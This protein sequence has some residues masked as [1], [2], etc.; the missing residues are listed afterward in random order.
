M[1]PIYVTKYKNGLQSF[2]HYNLQRKFN[3]RQIAT[4]IVEM[5][6]SC[7]IL[8]TSDEIPFNF[9]TSYDFLNTQSVQNSPCLFP[10][11]TAY[12]LYTRHIR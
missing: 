1:S 8:T 5:P 3:F 2:E 4:S 7:L 10:Q 11:N 6:K 12:D 9:M